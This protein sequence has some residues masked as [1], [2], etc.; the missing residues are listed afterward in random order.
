M[1]IEDCYFLGKI[2]KPHGLK[3]EVVV[4]LDVDAP[5]LY[6]EMDSVFLKIG[7]ELVPYFIEEIQIR[8]KKS[9]AKFED[10]ERLEDTEKIINKELYLPLDNLP[11]LDDDHSF[12]YHEIVGYALKSENSG[13]IIGLITQ[14]YE[15]SGQDLLAFEKEGKEVLIPISDEIV[16]T[17]DREAKTLTV[18]LPDGLLELYLES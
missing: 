8:G 9:I 11:E 2:T 6:A 17:L 16:K 7:N 12:Y 1:H 3:G 10:F 4:W 15:G 18:D 5:E 13:E 14:V